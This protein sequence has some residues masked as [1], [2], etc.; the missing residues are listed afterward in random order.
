MSSP[1]YTVK[2]AVKAVLDGLV[3]GG[4]LGYAG[5]FDFKKDPLSA[6]IPRFPAAYLM[7]P[8]TESEQSDNRTLLRTLTF[9]I[10]VLVRAEDIANDS[11]IE[12]LI[13]NILNA[14]DDVPTL[15]GAAN[16]ATEP[17]STTP[18]PVQHQTG[19]MVMFFIT[20]KAH[21]TYT[22]NF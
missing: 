19:N 10:M 21:L 3:T 4:T 22:Q 15:N 1:I 12:D 16:G 17:T 9:S 6:D 11:T 7:P 2:S 5:S 8:A 13:N 18:E 14:F 20:V